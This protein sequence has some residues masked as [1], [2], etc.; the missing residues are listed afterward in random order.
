MTTLYPFQ[1][2]NARQIR[3][4]YQGRALV[5]SEMG[6]GKTL[7]SLYYAQRM[8]RQRP[9]L[10]VCPAGLKWNWQ[11]EAAHHLGM[12]T[13][14]LHGQRPYRTGGLNGSAAH[15]VLI[16]NYQILKYWQEYLISLRPKMLILDEVHFLANRRS[17]CFKATRAICE[18][19]DI[20]YR[21][22]LSGTPLVNRPAELWT[23][24]HLLRPDLFPSFARFGFRW[25]CPKMVRGEWQFVGAQDLLELHARLKRVVMIR[26]LKREVFPEMPEKIRSVVPFQLDSADRKEYEFARRDFLRWLHQ[27][28]PER[29]LRAARAQAVTKVGYL[30]RLVTKLKRFAVQEWLENFTAESDEKIV[31]F[32]C[33]TK[34]IDWLGRKFPHHVR[35]DGQVTGYKRQL[36]VEA[37]QKDRSIRYAFCHPK[38]G[39]VGINLTAAAHVLYTD[40]PWTPGTLKQGEDRTHRIGQAKQ[41]HVWFLITLDTIESRLMKLLTDKQNILDQVL[42]GK[43]GGQDFDLFKRLL[44]GEINSRTK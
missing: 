43:T 33:H 8:R 44:E 3:D 42:D 30:L 37:F 31:V 13:E 22:A 14:I 7:Q 1:L 17:Q 2:E 38:A 5:A 9:V 21:L 40:L 23:T 27:V 10:I 26:Q 15:T 36:A 20:P 34:L 6:L 16:I 25:C 19:A 39:G 29:A 32:S 11:H 12:T 35:L 41:V 4:K 18:Q 24:L 28:S